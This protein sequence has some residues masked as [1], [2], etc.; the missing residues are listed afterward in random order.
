MYSM[1]M[2]RPT[3]QTESASTFSL[4]IVSSTNSTSETSP[5]VHV[6]TTGVSYFGCNLA[7]AFGNAPWL[8]I[9]S[10]VRAAGMIVAWVVAGAL[11]ST[12]HQQYTEDL[13][14]AGCAEH[15]AAQPGE[16]VPVLRGVREPDPVRTDP[17][18]NASAPT[19][20]RK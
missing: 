9:D 5:N 1:A 17:A 3:A 8:A 19:V 10:V 2:V 18:A 14:D 11:V 13:A 6:D 16:H 7:N 12:K 20:I 4:H 15:R